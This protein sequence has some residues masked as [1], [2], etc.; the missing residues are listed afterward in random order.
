MVSKNGVKKWWQKMM[1][2][3]E[4]KN[5]GKVFLSRGGQFLDSATQL[6]KNAKNY[7]AGPAIILGGS[8]DRP[9]YTLFASTSTSPGND[10][11]GVTVHNLGDL[12]RVI[13]YGHENDPPG[14]MLSQMA[15]TMHGT[16][17]TNVDCDAESYHFQKANFVHG[18]LYPQL[19]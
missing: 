16:S 11:T 8:P 18:A 12:R 10:Y 17:A 14:N 3:N 1:A 7:G 15:S 13:K 2:K 5:G 4:A 19:L 6:I 9:N